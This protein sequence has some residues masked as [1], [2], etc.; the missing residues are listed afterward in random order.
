MTISLLLQAAEQCPGTFLLLHSAC[1]VVRLDPVY[2]KHFP[3]L[4]VVI[5]L[6]YAATRY[7]DWGQISREAIR[8]GLKLLLFLV[9]IGAVLFG[10]TDLLPRILS[11]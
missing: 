8:W 11:W 9:L 2:Y 1:A 6:V 3:L 7:D 5:S 4:L 10:I